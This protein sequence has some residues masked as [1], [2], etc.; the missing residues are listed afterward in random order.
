MDTLFVALLVIH[1]TAA[2]VWVGGNTVIEFVFQR[3]LN[4]IN[5]SQAG[6][7]SKNAENAFT[8]MAW[9]AL[10]AMTV[11]G[12]VMAAMP[13]IGILPYHIYKLLTIDPAAGTVG[14]S[15]PFLLVSMLLTLVALI[16]ASLLTWYF[17]PRL[18][19]QKYSEDPTFRSRVLLSMQIQNRIAV[20]IVVLMAIYATLVEAPALMHIVMGVIA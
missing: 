15:G 2:A 11:T 10:A 7:I 18:N 20:V 3:E 13:E 6:L 1:V 17:P 16:N 5:S 9:G 12:L 19:L 8:Y 4:S 14:Y